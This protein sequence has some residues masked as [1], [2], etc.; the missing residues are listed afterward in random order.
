MDV[1][2]GQRIR[3]HLLAQ[4]ACLGRHT[5]T[6]LLTTTGATQQDWS[7]DYRLYSQG[8]CQIS[9]LFDPVRRSLC[10]RQGSIVVA[11]DDTRLPKTGRHIPGARYT[12]DPL[13]P[14]FHTNFIR[15]QR[16]LQV[17]MASVDA[18]QP[19]RTRM[20]PIDIAHTPAATKP[21]REAT[22]EDLKDYRKRK[23][24][25]ALCHVAVQRMEHLREAL[26]N[27]GHASQALWAVVDGGYTNST[28][29][30]NLP[31]RTILTGRIR[32]DAKLFFAPAN[33]PATGRRRIYGEQAP[34]PEQVRTDPAI[35]W[36]TIKAF[37][38]GKE[39]D[40]KV[41]SIGP[42]FWKKAGVN[43]PL[44]VIIIAPLAYR[45]RKADKPLYRNPAF[46]VCTDLDVPL[47]EVIQTYI[48]RWDIETNFRD[49]K[50]L[51]GLGQAQVRHAKSVEAVPALA[52]AAYAMLL[53]ASVL[54]HNDPHCFTPRWRSNKPPRASTASLINRLRY[55]LWAD[56]IRFHDFVPN[57]PRNTKS[58]KLIPSLC[59]SL[60]QA[61]S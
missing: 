24:E 46:L 53:C 58:S 15:A 18:Q 40:F 17:S 44:R 43:M 11:I 55:E 54:S 35:P 13:G 4:L 16:F 19:G 60:F 20:V 23:R 47:E 56:R 7:A 52:T 27:E 28:T 36:Q 22:E 10:P 5:I 34:T 41:K 57:L 49:Q 14:A 9:A 39:H 29:L 12:R 33:Q 30:K 1:C 6:G 32:K 25:Q 26:D 3:S 2:V 59:S 37:A 51:L 42:V 21:P 45:L 31:E 48:Y 61:A 50:T 8:K 38:C